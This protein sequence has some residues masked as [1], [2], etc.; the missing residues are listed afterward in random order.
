MMFM[1][2]PSRLLAGLL[3]VGLM[4]APCLRAAETVLLDDSFTDQERSTQN[5]PAS[6][7]WYHQGNAV[8]ATRLA[9]APAL[10][11]QE[12]QVRGTGQ[13]ALINTYFAPAGSPVQLEVGDIITVSFDLALSVVPNAADVVRFGLFNSQ[14][15]RPPG[16]DARNIFDFNPNYFFAYRG[17]STRFNPGSTAGNLNL[18]RRFSNDGT[19]PL[20]SLGNAQVG[21]NNGGVSLGL[22]ANQAFPVSLS[23]T[24]IDATTVT[25]VAEINGRTVS[26]TDTAATATAFD[27]LSILLAPAAAPANSTIALDNVVV[28]YKSLFGPA[29][30]VMNDSF[31]DGERSTQQLPSSA[32]W[33]YRGQTSAEVLPTLLGVSGGPALQIRGTGVDALVNTYFTSGGSPQTLQ[34]GDALRVNFRMTMSVVN[35]GDAV[36][37]FGLFNSANSRPP[38]DDAR[39]IFD[40]NPNYFF[41]YRGYSARINPGATA[42]N[43]NLYRRVSNDGTTPLNAAGN[44]Q[45]GLSNTNVALGIAANQPFP[46]SLTLTRTDAA[47][48]TFVVNVNGRSVSRTDTAAVATAFDAFSLLLAP[49]GAPAGA[50]ILID[51]M[52]VTYA[53]ATGASQIL[54]NDSFT[55]EERLT[56]T[57]PTSARWYYR[58]QTTEAVLPT[59]LGISGGFGPA[60]LNRDLFFNSDGSAATALAYFSNTASAPLQDGESI[61]LRLS[62]QFGSNRNAVNGFRVGLF[63]SAGSR[64]TTD[65]ETGVTPIPAGLFTGY[66]GYALGMNPGGTAAGG[67]QALKRSASGDTLFADGA[68]TTLGADSVGA[69]AFRPSD[70]TRVSLRL[71]KLG[72]TLRLEALVNDVWIELSDDSPDTFTFDTVAIFATGAALPTR[73]TLR[74]DDV[75]VVRTASLLANVVSSSAIITENFNLGGW[76]AA[77]FSGTAS[78]GT[79]SFGPHGSYDGFGSVGKSG[80][81]RLA[82]DSAGASGP[83]SSQWNSGAISITNAETNRGKLTLA[84]DLAASMPRPVRVILESLNASGASTGR[85]E[86]WIYPAAANF[87]QRFAFELSEMTAVEGTF[88]PAAPQLQLS[89]RIEGGIAAPFAWPAGAHALALDN[90]HLARPAYYVSPTGSNANNERFEDNSTGGNNGPFATLNAALAVAQPGDII[91]VRGSGNVDYTLSTNINGDGILINNRAGRPAAWITIKGYP[92]ETPEFYAPGWSVIRF[93]GGSS[94][95]RDRNPAV[96]YIELRG[97]KLTAK[98]DTVPVAQRGSPSIGASNS[99]GVQIEGRFTANRPHHI[100]IA[101]SVIYN[102]GGGGIA[103]LTADYVSLENNLVY[104]T[105]FLTVYAT[106]GISFFQAFNHAGRPNEYRLVALANETFNNRT[107]YNWVATGALSDGN[108]IIVDNLRNTQ[109]NLTEGGYGG[110]TLVQGNLTYRNGGSGAHT[111]QSERVDFINNT[112]YQNSQVLNYGELFSGSSDDV[113][114]INNIL[115]SPATVSGNPRNINNATSATGFP[116]VKGVYFYNNVYQIGAGSANP[117]TG[118]ASANNLTTTE[119]IFVDAAGFDFRLRSGSPATNVGQINDKV[120][121]VDLAGYPRAV[122]ATIDAGAYERQPIILSQP[123]AAVSADEGQTVVLTVGALGDDLSFQWQKNEVDLPAATGASLTLT[124]VLPS[125]AG[126]Y[127]VKVSTPFDSLTSTATSLV[128]FSS[129]EVWR[130]TYFGSVAATGNVAD[131]AD[132]DGDGLANLAEFALGTHPLQP[133]SGAA[134]PSLVTVSGSRYLAV[135]FNRSTTATGITMSVQSS[136]DLVNWTDLDLSGPLV[137]SETNAGGVQTRTVRDAQAIEAGNVGRFLRI[138][139]A[140]TPAGEATLLAP[141]GH[142]QTSA[143]ANNDTPVST[144]LSLLPV[145]VG[146]VQMA[147]GDVITVRGAPAWTSGQWANTSTQGGAYVRFLSGA[148][149]GH[150]VAITANT[151][152]AVSVD[153]AG[154]NLSTLAAGDRLEIVPFWTLGSL[155]PASAAGSAFI[156]SASALA[157]QT[158]LM[159]FDHQAIGVGRAPSA[160]YY[161]ANGAWRKVGAAATASF[162]HVVVLP[163]TYLLQ[164]NKATA[165]QLGRTGQ[166]S[167]GA[168]ST[169]IEAVVDRPNDNY[170]AL[171]YPVP[172]R[173]IDSGLETVVLDSGDRIELY[174]LTESGFGRRPNDFYVFDGTHWRKPDLPGEI[175]DNVA[176]R[177]GEGFVIRKAPGVSRTWTFGAGP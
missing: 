144:G 50:T 49:A 139:I 26:R 30:I 81:L 117:V 16:D 116:I 151:A 69:L 145:Y 19:T 150:Y 37:R 57:L 104:D 89:F 100:R 24:R 177:P 148:L 55:D 138:R 59:L 33:F 102:L 68:Y 65:F 67:L 169:I 13:D 123:P 48:M 101:D 137:V 130:R 80:G 20:N 157:R 136:G 46:V 158:E 40:S 173:L 163:D 8:A 93:A 153:A 88:D 17:Y 75:L 76:S 134:S 129:Q 132:P 168:Q 38:G 6:G 95:N 39:G 109:N 159:V 62:A 135:T 60:S 77:H 124:G 119:P 12:L 161:F 103:T 152:N 147:S 10:G 84:F 74:I 36:V 127:R 21:D 72:G 25:I 128:V 160:T 23:I 1:Y 7:R 154:L 52:N 142:L 78:N 3:L 175:Q 29:Q 22:S 14:G 110:R 166:V 141:V 108:G 47:T 87:L 92:G 167:V 56:Q 121:F 9:T 5:L 174:K 126:S 79:V 66:R 120:R 97:L 165:T 53:P 32:A 122:D 176:L 170:V 82:S 18:F 86:R 113:Y 146:Q 51:D 54:L 118:T 112:A 2:L 85:L 35:N 114:F 64:A 28:T 90:V 156:A 43:F 171:N 45:M 44:E 105:S 42:G 91:L 83:W 71:T 131:A 162:N 149:T 4:N 107:Q 73:A 143:P 31:N 111:F 41:A 96:S 11:S 115:V 34:V 106:S 133:T 63:D 61:V 98:S 94:A 58:G 15:N 27:A 172:V 125:D 155:Y 99:N 140:E 164:R 70:W